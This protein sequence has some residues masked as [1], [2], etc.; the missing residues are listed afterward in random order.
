MNEDERLLLKKMIAANNTKDNT[1]KIRELKHSSIIR[2]CI[3]NIVQLKHKY[4]RLEK[5]NNKQFHIMC[6]KNSKF[7]YDNYTDIYNKVMANELNLNTISQFLDVLKKIEDGK[8]NQHEGSYQ[9]GHILKKI[10]VDS[11]I[12]KEHNENAKKKKK[13]EKKIKSALYSYGLGFLFYCDLKL[14][15]FLFIEK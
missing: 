1:E 9:I 10:Y 14:K 7:L 11:A 3:Q 15:L 4:P 12:Q 5:T 13:K 2:T 8:L 6:M